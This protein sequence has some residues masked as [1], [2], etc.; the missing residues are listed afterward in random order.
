VQIMRRSTNAWQ[1]LV[2]NLKVA[3]GRLSGNRRV[4]TQGRSDQ[5]KARVK[6][7][8]E[9]VRVWRRKLVRS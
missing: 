7:A 3:F 1:R 5:M 8:R 4:A 9:N 2:G 6:D